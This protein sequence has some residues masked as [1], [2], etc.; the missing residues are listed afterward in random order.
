MV[1]IARLCP[2][3]I[4]IGEIMNFIPPILL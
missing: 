2:A 1:F 3:I 4:K